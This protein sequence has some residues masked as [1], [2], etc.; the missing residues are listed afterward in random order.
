MQPSARPKRLVPWLLRVFRLLVFVGIVWSIHRKTEWLAAQ[1]DNTVTLEMARQLFPEAARL[2]PVDP[3]TGFVD[4]LG[5]D[6]T[7][8]GTAGKTLPQSQRI[9]G[10]SGPHD[11]LIGR[12]PDGILHDVKLLRS[13]DTPEHVE[14][15]QESAAFWQQ[16]RTIPADVDAVSGASLT[17]HSMV[18]SVRH[19][20]NQQPEAG[21]SKLFPEEPTLEQMRR[22]FPTAT[23]AV[24]EN[25]RYAVRQAESLLGYVWRTSPESEKVS[26]YR[27]PT[28]VLVALDP[29]ETTVLGIALGKTYDNTSYVDVVR[30]DRG[31]LALFK[32]R[33]VETL[34]NLDY[35][36]EGIEGVSGSTLTSYAVAES[37]KKRCQAALT[38][39]TAVET[40]AAPTVAWKWQDGITIL[41]LLGSTVMAFSSWRG[42][43]W[44]RRSWQVI[45]AGG[46][47]FLTG[48]FLN[49][50]LFV[51]WAQHGVPWRI[52]PV[53]A[54]CRR[55]AG[56]MG[57]PPPTLLPP[58]LPLRSHAGVG[59]QTFPQKV[60]PG[61]Q[62]GQTRRV[63]A[64]PPPGHR[65]RAGRAGHLRQFRRLGTVRWPAVPR[66][67][68]DFPDARPHWPPSLPAHP[69]SLLPLRLPH[70]RCV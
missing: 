5:P 62:M 6:G 22:L 1:R 17:S 53:I 39:K 32:G 4:V 44:L 70:R 12:K 33:T 51:G 2:G 25:G 21:P 10:Y 13:R 54:R 31:Y 46:F 9:T 47:V 69:P 7:N 38:Q 16:L 52:V 56:S 27:G 24:L 58:N 23:S 59:W 57:R 34:A 43:P 65:H 42:K 15:V 36:K 8:V 50:A 55:P 35:E 18:E 3:A 48:S 63:P 45:L 64:R 26:G 67:S 60:V 40:T 14:M 61:I 41:F 30:D 49:L 37:L 66:R 19:R 29:T 28:D 68:L 20:L 11:L